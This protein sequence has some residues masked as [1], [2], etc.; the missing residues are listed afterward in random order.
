MCLSPVIKAGT[1]KTNVKSTSASMFQHDGVM[2]PSQTEGSRT[3]GG[4][5]SRSPRVLKQACFICVPKMNAR[6]SYLCLRLN[7]RRY[8]F[9]SV[10]KDVLP[11]LT[12]CRTGEKCKG[13][14]NFVDK[15]GRDIK[16][17]LWLYE[18]CPKPMFPIQVQI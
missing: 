5:S 15:E 17:L 10:S 16:K 1:Q 7:H 2:V 8:Y 18:F 14:H 6:L 13:F 4:F 3:L 12:V 9:P 11:F